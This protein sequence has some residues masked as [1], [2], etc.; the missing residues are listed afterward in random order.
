[1]GYSLL[2]AVVA[3]P[4][5]GSRRRLRGDGDRRPGRVGARLALAAGRSQGA[6]SFE[7]GRNAGAIGW[8]KTERG[9]TH[10]VI[11]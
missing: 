10:E 8:K 1:M 3:A 6:A 11:R 9:R 7:R 5:W 4:F 2:L